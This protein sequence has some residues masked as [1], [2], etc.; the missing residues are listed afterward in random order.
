MK[1][2]IG[3]MMMPLPVIGHAPKKQAESSSP[4]SAARLC[5]SDATDFSSA[6]KESNV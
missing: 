2:T 1:R 3:M 4:P 6:E 5:F